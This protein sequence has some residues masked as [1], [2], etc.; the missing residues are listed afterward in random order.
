MPWASWSDFWHMGG[1]GFFV[2]MSYGLSFGLIFLELW[3][4]RRARKRVF[5]TLRRWKHQ[6]EIQRRKPKAPLS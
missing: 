3:Q 1:A 4:L 6:H 2:W 5:Q